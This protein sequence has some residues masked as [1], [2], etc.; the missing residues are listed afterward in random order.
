MEYYLKGELRPN[1]YRPIF[2]IDLKEYEYQ[3]KNFNNKAFSKV[4]TKCKK[5]KQINLGHGCVQ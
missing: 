2:Y 1:K 5:M 4:V 3:K